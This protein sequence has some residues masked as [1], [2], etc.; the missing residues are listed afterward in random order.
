MPLDELLLRARAVR[1][2][3]RERAY[4]PSRPAASW[5]LWGP[6]GALLTAVLCTFCPTMLAHSTLLSSD[7]LAAL[8]LHASTWALWYSLH[9]HDARQFVGSSWPRQCLS[10][11]S[12]STGPLSAACARIVILTSA[13]LVRMA[14][15]SSRH[16]V[17]RLLQC[18]WRASAM[19]VLLPAVVSAVVWLVLLPPDRGSGSTGQHSALV[20]I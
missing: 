19:A 13:R 3:L 17:R 9:V 5:H 20:V 2:L 15:N 8:C 11:C 1:S 14:M 7:G 10:V 18:L 16:V 6:P 4:T 12:S